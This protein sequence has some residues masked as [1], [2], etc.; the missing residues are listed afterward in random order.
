MRKNIVV[1]DIETKNA[2]SDVGG[3]NNLKELG[4]SVLGLYDYADAQYKIYEEKELTIFVERL[5]K[6]PLL[7][8]FNSRK[9]DVPVL[10]NYV[11]FNLSKLPQLDI[12]EQLLN[13]LGHRVSLDSVAQATL[14][15]SKSGSGLDAIKF[16]REGR[17]E[18]LKKYCMDD[19]RI[20]KEIFEYGATHKELFYT[21]KFGNGKRRAVVNW[22]VEHPY[23]QTPSVQGS[24]F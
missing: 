7:V 18:E 4:I 20:T 10:Q 2:F 1:F 17:I 24:L 9:F 5:Q 19:V 11:P 12:M 15:A 13:A 6:S 21:S 14:G 16:F 22:S 3:R 8:G 23:E